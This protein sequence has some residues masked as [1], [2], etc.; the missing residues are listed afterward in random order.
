MKYEY[1]QPLTIIIIFYENQYVFYQRCKEL[2][3]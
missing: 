2:W 1:L 3:N